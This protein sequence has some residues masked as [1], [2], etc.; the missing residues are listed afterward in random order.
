[1]IKIPKTPSATS[2]NP[3]PSRMIAIGLSRARRKNLPGEQPIATPVRFQNPAYLLR[4]LRASPEQPHTKPN[5]LT[6]GHRATD[7]PSRFI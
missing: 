5:R 6:A 1:M 2:V 7:K 3:A 4:H